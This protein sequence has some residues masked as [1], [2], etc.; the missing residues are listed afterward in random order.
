M[1]AAI[2]TRASCLPRFP[3]MRVERF[4]SESARRF[5]DKT[6]L[7]AG[8]SRTNYAELEEKAN[9]FAHALRANGLR[10]GDRVVLFLANS[11]E[12]VVALFG[13]LKA[14]GVF[15]LVHPSTKA[16]KLA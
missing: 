11:T 13:T 5:P 6:A 3:R 9:R 10:R 1:H 2:N 8:G 7:V 12:A 4:L 14:G 16:E 15:T